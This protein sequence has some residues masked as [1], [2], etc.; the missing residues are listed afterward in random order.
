MPADPYEG[1]SPIPWVQVAPKAP[2]IPDGV[3]SVRMPGIKVFDTSPSF[4]DTPQIPIPLGSH[5]MMTMAGNEF[6]TMPEYFR[7][8]ADASYVPELMGSYPMSTMEQ[9]G[10]YTMPEYFQNLYH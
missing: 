1:V 5:P 9:H 10:M 6:W 3:Q 2:T 8:L 4:F 7:D